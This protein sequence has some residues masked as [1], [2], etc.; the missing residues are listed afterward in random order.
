MSD[1]GISVKLADGTVVFDTTKKTLKVQSGASPAHSAILTYTFTSEPSAGTLNL[2]TITHGYSYIPMVLCFWSFD[3]I[4]FYLVPSG[5]LIDGFGSNEWDCG[6]NSTDV[7]INY[8][9]IGAP[10]TPMLGRTVYFKYY[11][12]T[13]DGVTN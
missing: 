1:Y 13:E 5:F 6:A 10:L 8:I 12:S 7:T 9:K 3:N 2:F 11:I 4:T